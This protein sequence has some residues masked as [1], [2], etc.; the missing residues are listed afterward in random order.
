MNIGTHTR[1]VLGVVALFCTLAL[2]NSASAQGGGENMA[3]RQFGR[4]VANVLGGITEIP[5]TVHAVTREEGD[6]AGLT[7]GT[8]KGV[9]RFLTREVVGVFEV[10]TFP[11]GMEPIIEPEFPMQ[12]DALNRW[13]VRDVTNK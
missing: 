8:L 4:G 6:F 3:T 7:L 12:G 10:L 9:G 1:P 11:L 5:I 2:A 13:H